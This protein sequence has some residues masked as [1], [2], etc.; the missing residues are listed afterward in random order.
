MQKTGRTIFITTLLMLLLA[1]AIATTACQGTNPEPTPFPASAPVYA[2]LTTDPVPV[3]M[4]DLAANPA[5]YTDGYIQLTGQYERLPRLVCGSKAY[6]SPASWGLVSNGLM[7]RA[8]GFDDLL[9]NL[10]AR[11]LTMTV[12]G[13]WRQWQG[14]VGCGKN[15]QQQIIWYLEVTE[16]VSPSPL[17]KA[18]LTPVGAQPVA[19][20]TATAVP[21]TS[22]PVTPSPVPPPDEGGNASGDTA[23]TPPAPTATPTFIISATKDN[24]PIPAADTPTTTVSPIPTTNGTAAS[25]T[26][27]STPTPP[28]SPTPAT[29]GTQAPTPT[30]NSG[31]TPPPSA[32]PTSTPGST[33][34][35]EINQGSADIG[36]EVFSIEQIF[37][38]EYHTWTINLFDTAWVSIYTM[39]EPTMDLKVT[40]LDATGNVLI[41]QN[42]VPAGQLENIIE[43]PI[44]ADGLY[45]I[46][47]ETL[48][49]TSGYYAFTV[50]DDFAFPAI[51]QGLLTFNNPRSAS[52]PELTDNYWAF[53]ATAGSTVTLS[54][55][56]TNGS[57][58]YYL[59]SPKGDEMGYVSDDTGTGVAEDTFTITTT[60][61]HV[62]YL[63]EQDFAAA[64]YT[65]T[66]SNN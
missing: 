10:A 7:A 9:Q 48:N 54:V 18:T 8:K 38:D 20:V 65:I 28:L 33:A 44:S 26:P 5:F 43:F 13:F 37:P 15:A 17:V 32:A 2:P 52:I 59:Y 21:D 23:V 14:P 30:P 1:I 36:G 53:S 51:P 24:T 22:S 66:L 31:N 35:N 41:A 62:I 11:G 27:G 4:T 60:G 47:F 46:R 45:Q 42:N 40:L 25:S 64:D 58:F 63:G 3:L 6:P 50:Q 19:L 61:L 12:N 56:S 29:N 16:F 49:N 39:A 57:F 34:T 55:A